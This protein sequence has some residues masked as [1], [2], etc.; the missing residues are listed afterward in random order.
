MNALEQAKS[1]LT[2]ENAPVGTKAPA[3]TGGHWY[4]TEGGWKWGGPDGNGGTFPR[5]GGDWTGQLNTPQQ[6]AQPAL[7]GMTDEFPPLPCAELSMPLHG[8]PSVHLYTADQMREYALL[9][10]SNA[11]QPEAAQPAPR[12]KSCDGT[13]DVTDMTGEWRGACT[14][15][16]AA[17]P[18][19]M[20]VAIDEQETFEAF[21]KDK[22][23]D[24]DSGEHGY[25][26]WPTQMAWHVWQETRRAALPLPAQQVA[27]Q[28]DAERYRFLRS[29]IHMTDE[30]K[31]AFGDAMEAAVPQDVVTPTDEQFDASIDA[32][33]T[34]G[35]Q[36]K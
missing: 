32:A 18:A 17:Q 7:V 8:L 22:F 16:D 35:G 30:Q 36:E 6:A 10:R 21:A 3:I 23:F 9:S 12:C 11:Q 27:E 34:A 15:C 2:I 26:S 5:P 20:P 29:M 4:R 33:M 13:G 24:L 28:K 31:E 14:S 25:K 1:A 19:P